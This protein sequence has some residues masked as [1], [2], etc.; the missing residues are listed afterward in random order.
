M[1][2]IPGVIE[3]FTNISGGPRRSKSDKADKSGGKRV[4]QGAPIDATKY[5]ADYVERFKASIEKRQKTF[6][7]MIA[8]LRELGQAADGIVE[9][10]IGVKKKLKTN[11]RAKGATLKFECKKRPSSNG[12][13]YISIRIRRDG[14][15][16]TKGLTGVESAEARRLLAPMVGREVTTS[17]LPL[18]EQINEVND[19]LTV[20]SD[21]DPN[22]DDFRESGPSSLLKVW[23]KAMHLYGMA[24]SD[25]LKSRIDE[26]LGVDAELLEQAF[27]FNH[28]RNNVR[29]NS[30]LCRMVLAP[31]DPLG[32]RGIQFRVVKKIVPTTGLRVSNP[33][34]S[35]KKYRS[36][37]QDQKA[38]EASLGRE[39]TP[40]EVDEVRA[41]RRNRSYTP[42][43]TVDLISHCYLGT[44][45]RD[46]LHRQKKIVACM[47]SWSRDRDFFQQ[48]HQQR[49]R[50]CKKRT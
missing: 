19:A 29:W 46:V 7:E 37:L 17:L 13:L 39:P 32:P 12:Q 24:A 25:A 50:V 10:A 36:R 45:I 47:E 22:F 15:D 48:L 26:F 16:V 27:L 3:P 41:K 34:V 5:S 20:L 11:D 31:A 28:E 33:L 23:S 9:L 40:E 6:D 30:I 8:W 43:I 38:L 2:G 4:E 42:W 1:V 35:V 44:Q 18:I 49:V 14:S 21:L